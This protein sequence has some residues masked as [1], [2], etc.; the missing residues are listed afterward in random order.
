MYTYMYKM[1]NVLFVNGMFN[2]T[3]NYLHIKRWRV[4]YTISPI[5][6]YSG[7][8]DYRIMSHIRWILVIVLEF[9]YM[10]KILFI[11]LCLTELKNTYKDSN[12]YW[13]TSLANLS[14]FDS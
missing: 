2:S 14:Y 7:V 12:I 4:S 10:E 3:Y 9:I 5:D 6:L 13:K 11:I 8:H 1:Q